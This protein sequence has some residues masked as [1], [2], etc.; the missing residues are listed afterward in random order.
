M[1]SI[2]YYRGICAGSSHPSLSKLLR[3]NFVLQWQLIEYFLLENEQVSGT[4]G[5]PVR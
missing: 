5:T 1:G 3:R 4:P 2:L